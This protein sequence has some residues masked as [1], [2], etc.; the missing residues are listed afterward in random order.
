MHFLIQFSHL[1][2]GFGFF[3]FVATPVFTEWN[4]S[5]F[6]LANETIDAFIPDSMYTETAYDISAA[7]GKLVQTMERQVYASHVYAC[8]RDRSIVVVWRATH[9]CVSMRNAICA[10]IALSLSDP[11]EFIG[12]RR[13]MESTTQQTQSHTHGAHIEID[14]LLMRS[15]AARQ[16]K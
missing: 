7:S 10:C 2:I 11:F 5:E 8:A 9:V 15:T 1:H 13:G 14:V 16:P 6:W 4:A 3:N 12:F